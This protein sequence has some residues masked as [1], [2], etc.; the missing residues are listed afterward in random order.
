MKVYIHIDSNSTYVGN[1]GLIVLSNLAS[2]LQDMGYEVYLFDQ[3]N[4]LKKKNLEWVGLNR[5]IPIIRT[6][7]I[8]LNSNARIVTN[9]LKTLP[10]KFWRPKT[11]RFLESSEL[12]RNGHEAEREWLIKNNVKIANLHRH[13]NSIYESL[14]IKNMINLDVWI[15]EDVKYYGVKKIN[16]SVGIQ[17]EKRRI[18]K[19]FKI[20]DWKRYGL[21]RDENLIV[22][23]GTYKEV[24]KAMNLADFYIHNPKPSP[25]I[26]IF[27]GETF[28]LPLFEAMACGCIC[29]ARRHLGI[30]FLKDTIF[31]VENMQEAKKKLESIKN[32]GKLEKD[33]I[34]CSNIKFIEEN[35]RFDKKRKEA[36]QEWLS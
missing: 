4:R 17:L 35:F 25:H 5:Q 29:I 33:K 11:I 10:R 18:L 14:G 20:Y 12:L 31:L 32:L 3:A 26:S 15:R 13:L 6:D 19:I 23:N 30:D 36:I 34:R 7:K 28:G 2:K 16:N 27:K 8:E 1:G 24:I 22:C 9:W 21:F